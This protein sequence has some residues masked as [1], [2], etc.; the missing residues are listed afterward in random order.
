MLVCSTVLNVLV[1]CVSVHHVAFH[2][3]ILTLSIPHFFDCGKNESTS[4]QHHTGL[5]HPFQ[6]FDIRALCHSVLSAR[7]PGCQKKF[8]RVG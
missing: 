6:F 5:T 8:K 1:F 7:V 4:V 3:V 2:L